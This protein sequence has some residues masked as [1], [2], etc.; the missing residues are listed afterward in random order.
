MIV[1]GMF[2]KGSF[3]VATNMIDFMQWGDGGIGREGL[4][5]TNGFW[6]AGTFINITP[7]YEF[8]GGAADFGVNFWDTLLGVED[9]S[10]NTKFSISPNPAS[11][12]LQ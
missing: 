4:A 9:I 10:D 1:S 8:T 2:A 12:I 5:V 6:T 3:G 11:D 7:P